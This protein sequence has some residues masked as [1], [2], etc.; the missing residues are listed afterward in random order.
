M[1][2]Y[3]VKSHKYELEDLH[4]MQRTILKTSLFFPTGSAMPWL[5][6]WIFPFVL[7]TI[8]KQKQ[9]I[10]FYNVRVDARPMG[11][12]SATEIIQTDFVPWLGSYVVSEGLHSVNFSASLGTVDPQK[13]HRILKQAAAVRAQNWQ[14]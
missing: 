14:K 8:S 12:F 13:H 7:R 1:K 2:S 5:D 10:T 3:K 11:T 4:T 6:C 9:R